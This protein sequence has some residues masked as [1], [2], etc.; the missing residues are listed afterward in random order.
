LV[1]FAASWVSLSFGGRNTIL[2]CPSPIGNGQSLKDHVEPVAGL[3]GERRTDRQPKVG[4]I[5]AWLQHHFAPCCGTDIQL[6]AG[7]Q[8]GPEQTILRNSCSE[9]QGRSRI[10][11]ALGLIAGRIDWM[12][13]FHKAEKIMRKFSHWY[14]VEGPGYWHDGQY[15]RSYIDY[16]VYEDELTPFER[17]VKRVFQH[18]RQLDAEALILDSYVRVAQKRVELE[19]LSNTPVRTTSNRPGRWD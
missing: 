16:P 5:S 8:R 11:N 15:Y 13:R 1:T 10:E 2:H 18:K 6:G 17:E 19:K 14:T 3:V 12:F 7:Q 4:H 9:S